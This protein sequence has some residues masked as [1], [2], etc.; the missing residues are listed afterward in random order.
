MQLAIYPK[1][2][3][4]MTTS[5]QSLDSMG[6]PTSAAS[7]L[8]FGFDFAFYAT[9]GKKVPDEDV[10]VRLSATYAAWLAEE[11]PGSLHA[12]LINGRVRTKLRKYA[13]ERTWS[14]IALPYE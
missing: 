8:D 4:A 12:A 7:S 2:A 6:R 3:L 11:G 13:P 5:S 10:L 9:V 14:D 1:I